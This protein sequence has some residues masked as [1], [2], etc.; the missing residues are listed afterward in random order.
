MEDVCVWQALLAATAAVFT[1]PTYRLF[2]QL[3]AGWILCPVRRTVTG[4]IPT[5]DPRRPHDAYHYF[6]RDA[7]WKADLLWSR[8]AV[9]LVE[10][11]CPGVHPVFVA[12]AVLT[13]YGKPG[14]GG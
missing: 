9:P 13:V 8:M 5:A 2:C 7:A 14:I 3:A 10:A 1:R 6:F 12:G 4:M 11:T